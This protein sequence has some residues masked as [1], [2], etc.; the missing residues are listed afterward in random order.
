[1]VGSST[2]DATVARIYREQFHAAVEALALVGVKSSMGRREGTSKRGQR[3]KTEG[4]GEALWDG[5]E[6]MERWMR[7]LWVG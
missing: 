6:A 2:D 1:V 3:G 5:P 4:D 7:G